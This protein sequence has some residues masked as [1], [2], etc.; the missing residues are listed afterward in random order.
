MIDRIRRLFR[1]KKRGKEK[2]GARPSL[3]DPAVAQVEVTTRCNL[4]CTMCPRTHFSGDKNV[5]FPFEVFE[6]FAESFPKFNHVHLQGW[7]EPLLHP[8]IFDMAALVTRNQCRVG[9]TTNG[10]LL[11]DRVIG[12]ILRLPVHHVAVSVA[13]ADDAVHGA[14]RVGSNLDTL[15]GR[16]ANLVDAKNAAGRSEPVVH[17]SYMMTR[18][19]AAGLP[20]MV[21]KAHEIGVDRL[22]APNLDCPVTR[23]EDEERIFGFGEPEKAI[24]KVLEEARILANKR[25]FRL[26]VYPLKLSDE[27]LVCELNPLA[28]FFVNVHGDVAPCPYASLMGRTPYDRY[29]LGETV[30][31]E[32]LV[33]GS[34]AD[35]SMEA[36]WQREA[37]REFRVQYWNRRTAYDNLSKNRTSIHSVFGLQDYIREIDRVLT[38]YPVPPFCRQCYKAYGA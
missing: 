2:A 13:G 35:S 3:P 25:K 30:P 29:F 7:G 6:S 19:S 4:K 24:E 32:P 9:F 23:E 26:S 36:V 37:Y 28:Q 17:L 20:E 11:D 8:R 38:Q 15:L 12:E 33:F 5:D 1:K 10:T 16:V 34:L 21:R 18:Q 22:V 27:I 31:T 14:I